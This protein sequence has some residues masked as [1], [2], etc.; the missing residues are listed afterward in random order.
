MDTN[1][2]FDEVYC[3]NKRSSNQRWTKVKNRFIEENIFVK[4]IDAIT[5]YDKVAIDSFLNQNNNVSFTDF[6]Y[7]IKTAAAYCSHLFCIEE[8]E[9]ENYS[10]ILIFED[11]I[12]FHNNYQELF[13]QSIN[14]IPDDWDVWLLGGFQNDWSNTILTGGDSESPSLFYISDV[15]MGM[16]AYAVSKKG[17]TKL[18][19]IFKEYQNS[20]ICIDTVLGY[21]IMKNELLNV[22]I[23]YPMLVGHDTIPS[24]TQSGKSE[25]YKKYFPESQYKY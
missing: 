21:I 10:R 12:I 22:Y 4:R 16:F 19:N 9:K 20:N 23:S 17:L 13:K 1:Q 18:K 5:P 15:T 3:I 6:N 25:N 24:T 2:Y 14:Q 7:N 11:D 8:S